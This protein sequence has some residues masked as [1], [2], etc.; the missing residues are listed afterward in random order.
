MLLSL[1][2]AKNINIVLKDGAMRRFF[3]SCIFGVCLPC[4]T[5][6]MNVG[7]GRILSCNESARIVLML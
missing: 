5:F 2:P 3:V 1:C 6:W 7:E 4:V